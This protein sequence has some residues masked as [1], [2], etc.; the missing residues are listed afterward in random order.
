MRKKQW[1]TKMNRSQ[2]WPSVLEAVSKT[3]WEW[4][5]V[6]G[7]VIMKHSL[8]WRFFTTARWGRW[9]RHGYKAAFLSSKAVGRLRNLWHC[10][11]A[12]A[13][14]FWLLRAVDSVCILEMDPSSSEVSA[15]CN[16]LQMMLQQKCDKRQAAM[17][18]ESCFQRY[19][20]R[21]ANQKNC[22]NLY[23][24]RHLKKWKNSKVLQT[25]KST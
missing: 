9:S 3:E 24:F 18:S 6:Y 17:S 16:V 2:G 4:A 20:K 10:Q 5:G 21:L 12:F 14:S 11:T 19:L 25:L 15:C 1:R 22:S 23:S 8:A 7:M 13:S